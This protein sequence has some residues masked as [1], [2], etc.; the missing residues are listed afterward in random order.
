MT[1]K[2]TEAP[3]G[4][5]SRLVDAMADMVNPQ[6]TKT[7]K[8][9]TKS[10]GSYQYKYE[11]LDQVLAAVRPPLMERKIGLTQRQVWSENTSSYALETVV[12]DGNEEIVL[13]TRPM[14]DSP[15]AQASGS[16]ETYMRRYAL[17]SA[18]G[19][20]G[21]DDD[22]AAGAAQGHR[23]SPAP[24]R[25]GK[26]DEFKRLK[27]EAVALGVRDESI[28]EWM[29]ATFKK[30]MRSY[31]PGDINLC[32]AHVRQLIE[33]AKKIAA[34]SQQPQEETPDEG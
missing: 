17:R 5:K 33:D 24:K 8:V 7:A 32:E 34:Q 23:A 27:A 30:D 28:K 4:L 2:A 20:A 11:S 18:F 29:N 21:E 19:L 3:Q 9:P 6:K 26:W 16:W 31:T 15:D 14:R 1:E 22:G 25:P 10:G 12:F 13:D